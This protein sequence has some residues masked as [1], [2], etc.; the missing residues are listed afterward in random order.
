MILKTNYH[1]LRMCSK[2]ADTFIM[3][4][5]W[6]KANSYSAASHF[7]QSLT[8]CNETWSYHYISTANYF[9]FITTNISV[10]LCMPKTHI[11]FMIVSVVIQLF[12]QVI[13]LICTIHRKEKT[14]KD[15]CQIFGHSNS[16]H[17]NRNVYCFVPS[18]SAGS[19][20]HSTIWRSFQVSLVYS[21]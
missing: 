13:I 11:Q 3:T 10:G 2:L 17:S 12:Q 5:T 15:P 16:F 18:R 14:D 20:I 7:S 1:C 6:R 8:R 4:A 9:C 19:D 21:G